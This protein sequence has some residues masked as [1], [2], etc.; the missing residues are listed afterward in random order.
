MA[1]T[2][3]QKPMQ[4]C[5]DMQPDELSAVAALVTEF[6]DKVES[7]EDEIQLLKQDQKELVEEYADRV[8]VK[9]L[10]QVLRVLKIEASV[11]HKDTYDVM[12]G[13]LKKQDQ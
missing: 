8:D 12:Y 7:I 5:A 10:R 13:A 11:A 2:K 1:R 9:T 3:K 6:V 4:N